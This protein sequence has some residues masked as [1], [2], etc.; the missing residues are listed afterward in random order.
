MSSRTYTFER[1]PDGMTG[2]VVVVRKG[3]NLKGRLVGAL[4]GVIGTRFFR[5][6][7]EKTVKA[8]EARTAATASPA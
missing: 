1:R 4:L 8:V 2:I 5:G 6:Q 3:K 7:F